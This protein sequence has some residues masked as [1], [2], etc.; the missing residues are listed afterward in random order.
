MQYFELLE[1]RDDSLMVNSTFGQG[2]AVLTYSQFNYNNPFTVAVEYG[3][4]FR[5][6]YE[7]WLRYY[8]AK[9]VLFLFYEDLIF[10]STSGW[11]LFKI[12]LLIS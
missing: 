1:F 8:N 2:G 12:I 11:L 7:W 6:A 3:D 9:N 10:V 4:W 5:N